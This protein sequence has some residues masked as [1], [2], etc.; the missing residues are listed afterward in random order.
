METLIEP[1]ANLAVPS[2][3]EDPGS[4]VA[5]DGYIVLREF[6]QPGIEHIWRDFLDR[7]ESPAH[8]NA[9]EFFLEPYWTDQK[10]F[11]IL[12]LNSGRVR[13]AVTGLDLGSEVICGLKS[14][15][16][17]CVETAVGSIDPSEVLGSALVKLFPSA[18]LITL[19]GWSWT[20]LPGLKRHGFRRLPLEGNIVLDLRPGAEFLFE[21]FRKNRRRD[22]RLALRSGV[23][24]SE[25]ITTDDLKAYWQVYQGWHQTERKEIRHDADLAKVGATVKLRG[26]HRRLVAWYKGEPI[27][28]SGFR[29]YPTGLVEY[30]NNCSRDEYLDLCPNDLL[31][32]KSIE[33]ACERAYPTFSLGG[34]HA[35]LAKWGDFVVPIYRYRH[36]R[37]FGHWVTL[38]EETVRETRKL[39]QHLPDPMR[40]NLRRAFRALSHN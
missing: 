7:V 2:T 28:A 15:P 3:L 21:H 12:V 10:P 13:A 35:F 32:W 17:V 27:A 39:T 16:Q 1:A 26:S 19:Y 22:I 23:E 9:P 29:F 11:A 6:P 36:D 5:S 20:P 31:L 33:W 18:K 24:V 40:N 37:T 38:R 14:R 30:S 34:V 25:V 4:Q 8:Y